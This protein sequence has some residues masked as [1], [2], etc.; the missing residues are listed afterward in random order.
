MPRVDCTFDCALKVRHQYPSP[1]SEPPHGQLRLS[2]PSSPC[3]WLEMHHKNCWPAR[4]GPR[5][6]PPAVTQQG[7][8]PDSARHGQQAAL[9]LHHPDAESKEH[10][11]LVKLTEPH[12][13]EIEELVNG[14]ADGRRAKFEVLVACCIDTDKD[15]DWD[16]MM[17]RHL[18]LEFMGGKEA[19][20]L[21]QALRRLIDPTDTGRWLT[22]AGLFATRSKRRWREPRQRPTHPNKLRG[23]TRHRQEAQLL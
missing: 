23:Y 1:T 17:A 13:D 12:H 7:P 22:L 19:D 3:R 8:Q 5:R 14:T 15:A 18:L 4:S 16:T 11:R 20:D 2:G 6:R 21:R 9:E 10:E